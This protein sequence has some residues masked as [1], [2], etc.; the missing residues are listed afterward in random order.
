MLSGSQRS[1][2]VERG[3]WR[4]EQKLAVLMKILG[5]TAISFCVLYFTII[6]LVPFAWTFFGV[7][8]SD[9][10]RLPVRFR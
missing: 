3:Y 7:I 1:P 6:L 2:E 5:V 10:W 9:Q 8:I 4:A